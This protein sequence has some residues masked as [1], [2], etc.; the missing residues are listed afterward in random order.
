MFIK[1]RLVLEL[2]IL[3]FLKYGIFIVNWGVLNFYNCI[4]NLFYFE[5]SITELVLF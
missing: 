3:L 4:Y 2:F 5:I 1:Y